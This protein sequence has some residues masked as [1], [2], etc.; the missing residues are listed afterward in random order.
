ME[1]KLYVQIITKD[2]LKYWSRREYPYVYIHNNTMYIVN[3]SGLERYNGGLNFPFSISNNI[4]NINKL[5]KIVNIIYEELE[6]K[7][8][9]TFRF[10][11]G[12]HYYISQCSLTVNDITHFIM[13]K[14]I[15]VEKD[16]IDHINHF[17]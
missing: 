4:E 15:I 5:E 6:I 8:N 14:D 7:E 16:K 17:L 9:K 12:N 2:I 10:I 1:D 3:K 11:Y 13:I